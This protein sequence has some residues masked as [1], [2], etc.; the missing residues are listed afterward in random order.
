MTIN[1]NSGRIA[2]KARVRLAVLVLTFATGALLLMLVAAAAL[3]SVPAQAAGP[4][5]NVAYVF[6]FNIGLGS[7]GSSP[8]SDIFVNAVTPGS[9][10]FS[11][12]VYNGATFT[13]V[14]LSTIVSG[15]LT[16]S[17]YDTVVLYET[18][19]IG[20]H[21]AAMTEINAFLNSGHK[22]L[23]FTGDLCAGVI[24]GFGV[25]D[26]S[27]F[28]FPFTT[29][30]PG[31]F[32]YHLGNY[33]FVEANTLTTTPNLLPQP[34]PANPL[35]AIPGDAVGDAS[36]M[37]TQDPAWCL[38]IK[39]I[40]HTGTDGP[41]E[42]YA[43]PS[44]GGLAIY[45]GEDFWAGE[46]HPHQKQVF[47]NMLAQ[48]WNPDGLPCT[49][50]VAG[51]G[52][53][54]ICKQTDPDSPVGNPGF[55]FDWSG[56]PPPP[57]TFTLPVVLHDNDCYT[58][59]T[60]SLGI[61]NVSELPSQMPPG[62]G[63][64]NIV[65]TDASS[66]GFFVDPNGFSILPFRQG[67]TGVRINLASGEN[68]TC[69]FTNTY[70]PCTSEGGLNISTGTAGVGP[71]GFVDPQ[72]ILTSTPVSSGLGPPAYGITTLSGW[73][74]PPATPISHWIHP[75]NTGNYHGSDPQLMGDYVYERTFSAPPGRTK[76]TFSYEFAA[77]ND[78]TIDLYKGA[79]PTYTYVATIPPTP[80]PAGAATNFST[81]HS[82]LYTVTV[83][84]AGPYTLR[85]TVYN[86]PAV[87]IPSP[88]TPEGFL[89]AGFMFC[90]TTP[91][92]GAV[93]LSVTDSGS[94]FPSMPLAAVAAG[95]M[96]VMGAGLWYG[97]RRWLR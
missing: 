60:P 85:A 20:T 72:W 51:S 24:P 58:I 49:H 30:D 33:T 21:P 69:T 55:T 92:G 82:T 95:V 88:S 6:D 50:S 74:T 16:S 18:C 91:V 67:D 34:C 71:P 64:T 65:C 53:I 8:S 77:D 57:I 44:G 42:A 4:S 10:P 36:V 38:S 96:A 28:Q 2:L 9:S 26:F 29:S 68:V 81:L 75:D 3:P 19:T 52:S 66:Y 90:A 76:L 93:A 78:V 59:P 35:C 25:A 40:N 86:H 62:W 7:T 89:L 17:T 12:G 54:T 43:R 11:G 32:G 13:N 70:F 23:I 5:A 83:P 15:T 47:D 63:L 80:L 87:A 61:Y 1:A 46:D 37:V 45:N 56:P 97:R 73:A 48:N 31:P 27:G 41:I 22:V 14:P 79:N 39:G 84:S 94:P